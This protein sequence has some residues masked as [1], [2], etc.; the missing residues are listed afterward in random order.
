MDARNA[1]P[2]M[3]GAEWNTKEMAL[4]NKNVSFEF[5]WFV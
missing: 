2:A 3:N 4:N 5:A 1:V